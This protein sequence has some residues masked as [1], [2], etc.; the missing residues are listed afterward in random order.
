MGKQ[1]NN[2]SK[3]R[4]LL[5]EAYGKVKKP[6]QKV[7][8][9]GLI[10]AFAGGALGHHLAPDLL[11]DQLGKGIAGA[12]TGA[13]LGH[14]AEDESDKTGHLSDRE[15]VARAKEMGT[16]GEE[17]IEAAEKRL[18]AGESLTPEQRT[19]LARDVYGHAEQDIAR[20]RHHGE[21]AEAALV[22]G[23]GHAVNTGKLYNLGQ[24][25]RAAKKVA[26]D[27]GNAALVP[28][29][30]HA[31][32]GGVGKAALD[33]ASKVP[34]L[35]RAASMAK[36][37]LAA[38]KGLGKAKKRIGTEDAEDE[39]ESRAE[40][41]DVDRYEYEQGKEAGEHEHHSADDFSQGDIVEGVDGAEVVVDIH[42]GVVY[43]ME[44]AQGGN[45][46]GDDEGSHDFS[47]LT[48]IKRAGEDIEE[49]E[50]FETEY[51]PEMD[52]RGAEHGFTGEFKG[53]ATD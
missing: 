19:A 46:Y 25:L 10:G 5:A 35:G 37:A 38:K 47:D 14:K 7:V 13:Y 30:G 44:I 17:E 15:I 28:G 1:H 24:Q 51:E 36:A 3:D 2:F 40:R 45:K 43:T 39:Y 50:D 20:D 21:D 22:P 9:E 6:K 16:A 27:L 18:D 8:E 49:V 41:A 53:H 29:I 4:D 33:A 12:A 31:T 52:L 48:I 34:I 42:E 23:I 26:P 11:K 32:R